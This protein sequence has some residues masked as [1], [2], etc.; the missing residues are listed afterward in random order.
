[1][2]KSVE[3]AKAQAQKLSAEHPHNTVRVLDKPRKHA[4][5]CASEW[6]YRER[7]LD[8]WHVVTAYRA[9]KE[10]RLWIV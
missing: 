1:M 6:A 10:V 7:I 9:G 8:G 2:K 5:V 4:V 3:E